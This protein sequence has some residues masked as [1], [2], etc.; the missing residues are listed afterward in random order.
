MSLLPG[1]LP[2]SLY[3][4]F[5]HF[6]YEYFYDDPFVI[7]LYLLFYQN[8]ER[9]LV[10]WALLNCGALLRL[11]EERN[12]IGF[13]RSFGFHTL[14]ADLLAVYGQQIDDFIDYNFIL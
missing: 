5:A 9:T 14:R 2:F 10:L 11:W 7:L 13:Q 3:F 8:Y 1:D 4:L 12:F 6:A